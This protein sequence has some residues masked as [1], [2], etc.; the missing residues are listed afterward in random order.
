MFASRKSAPLQYNDA[1]MIAAYS[2]VMEYGDVGENDNS[3]C[4]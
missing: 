3:Q 2:V 4:T 1:A